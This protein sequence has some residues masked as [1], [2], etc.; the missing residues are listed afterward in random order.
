MMCNPHALCVTNGAPL[1]VNPSKPMLHGPG[2]AGGAG[3]G[4]GA[5]AGAGGTGGTAVAGVGVVRVLN[6]LPHAAVTT[7]IRTAPL[8]RTV[9]MPHLRFANDSAERVSAT[10]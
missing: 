5:G 8:N 7:A 9:L 1:M 10:S 6:E 2:T 4:I 3:V